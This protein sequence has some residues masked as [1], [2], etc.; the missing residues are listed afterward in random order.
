MGATADTRAALRRIGAILLVVLTPWTAVL[1]NG[2]F[3]LVFP[4]AL[5]DPEP[6]HVTFL[7][8]Y[9][10]RFTGGFA[11]LPPFLQAWPLATLALGAALAA[12]LVAAATGHEDP[13]LTGGLLALSGITSFRLA[14][15]FLARP[16]QTA[17]PVGGL[18][19]IV[20]AWWVYWPLVRREAYK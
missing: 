14:F 11:S 8:D 4:W 17:I 12:A 19:A 6:L 10:F 15:G 2:E 13:R 18:V 16:N 9:L 3:T 1:A 7:H 5:V 20:L